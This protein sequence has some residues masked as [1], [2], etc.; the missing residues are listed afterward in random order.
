MAYEAQAAIELEGLARG[1]SGDITAY[2]FDIDRSANPALIDPTPVLHAVV[3]DQRAR[4]PAAVIGARFHRAVAD[5]VVVLPVK[6]G[7]HR[8]PSRCLEASSRT[9]CYFA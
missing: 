6:T 5:L 8:K 9:R 3:R 7:M 4:V 2:T 1:A